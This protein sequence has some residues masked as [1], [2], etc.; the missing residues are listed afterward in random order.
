MG[1]QYSLRPHCRNPERRKKRIAAEAYAYA[2]T[3]EAEH[4]PRELKLI[5][6]IKAYGAAAV[7]MAPLTF[8]ELDN[9]DFAV[10]VGVA[11]KHREIFLKEGGQNWAA[12]A[13]ENKS[14]AELLA[15]GELEAHKR[16]LI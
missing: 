5:K 6:R 1:G 8:D 15:F 10:G 14:L 13:K 12:W 7:L 4:E 16:N 9:M 11:F 3:G 2:S